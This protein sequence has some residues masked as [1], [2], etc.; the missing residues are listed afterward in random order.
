MLQIDLFGKN[1]IVTG[2]ANGLSRSIALSFAKAGANV[3]VA[4]FDFEGAKKV[5]GEIETMGKKSLA[6]KIDV[7]NY[8]DFEELMTETEKQFGSIEI[9]INGAGIG[10]MFPLQDFEVNLVERI[11]DIDLKGT[12]WGCKAV[13]PYMLAQ[14]YGKIVN[15]S[16]VA[17]RLLTP[18]TT[19]YGAA[20]AGVIALT[21]AVAREVAADNI[22]INSVL[23]GIIRTNMWQQTLKEWA[24][25]DAEKQ[26]ALFKEFCSANIPMQRPQDP[27][28]I[29]NMVLFLC[30][31]AAKNITGQ[32]IA[33]D[34]GAT[35]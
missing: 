9:L 29:A 15:I 28:D 32:Y 13:L 6:Y 34:G 23:P 5:A 17:A 2:A 30:S 12:I 20:K 4:D 1:A 33:V 24:P 10:A 18:G 31:E 8:K 27:E 35:Y 11:I 25:G 19:A 22:N 14:K 16:S 26:N 3:I 7:S 21:T